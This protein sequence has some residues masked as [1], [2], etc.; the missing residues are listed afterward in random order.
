MMG[1]G[2]PQQQQGMYQQQQYPQSQMQ[3][4]MQT[5]FGGGAMGS[6]FFSPGPQ[7]Y[8]SS[9]PAGHF[10]PSSAF[11]QQLA[12]N[13]SGSSYGYL[14]GQPQQQQQNTNAYNPAQ[15]QL[16]NNPGYV[17][18]LDPYSSLAQLVDGNANPPRSSSAANNASYGNP[19]TGMAQSLSTGSTLSSTSS[20]FSSSS[21]G[22]SYGLGPSGDS[23]PKD[24]IRTHK[25]ELEAWDTYTWKQLL[26]SFEA[27]RKAWE[28][29]KAELTNKAKQ[30]IAQGQMGMAY[31]GYYAQQIQQEAANIQGLL[32]EAESNF[33][34]V[35][36]ST[37]QMQEVFQGYRQSGDLAS[38][39]RVREATNAALQ[40][41]PGWPQPYQSSL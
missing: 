10:Q 15:Q 32:K 12:A 30:V 17:A 41:L 22:S 39:R 14:N 4:P 21:S 18:Q 29:R 38:K 28:G 26:S 5:G 13:I 25:A 6:G 36:A 2:Y 20:S 37:F 8:P 19:N 33:D 34:S 35:T 31:G 23:H 9:P 11:G 3:Q 16:Q 1:G 24:Y 40:G 27:M 7:S